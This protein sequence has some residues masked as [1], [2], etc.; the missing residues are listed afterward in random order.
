MGCSISNDGKG[1]VN[2]CSSIKRCSLTGG[3]EL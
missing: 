2:R 1:D 3:M